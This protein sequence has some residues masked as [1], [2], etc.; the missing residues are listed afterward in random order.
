MALE[1]P[2]KASAAYGLPMS[3]AKNASRIASAG[4]GWTIFTTSA[5]EGVVPTAASIKEL[6]LTRSVQPLLD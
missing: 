1:C 6:F 4:F 5:K 2:G 3:H